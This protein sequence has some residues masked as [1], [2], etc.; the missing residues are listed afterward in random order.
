MAKVTITIE[1]HPGGRVEFKME[2]SAETLIAMIASGHD[3]TG[4]ETYAMACVNRVREISRSQSD[5]TTIYI[6]RIGRK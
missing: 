4:A 2:P 1:D 5:H 6:P 3:L